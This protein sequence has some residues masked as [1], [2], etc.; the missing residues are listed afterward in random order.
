MVERSKSKASQQAPV[1]YVGSQG[2]P[3]EKRVVLIVPTH[4]L[5]RVD[6]V[7]LSQ[8]SYLDTLQPSIN[9]SPCYS[10]AIGKC[11]I[12]HYFLGCIHTEVRDFLEIDCS[13]KIEGLTLWWKLEQ[14]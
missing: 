2:T 7:P 10:W 6:I 13:S 12:S 8:I 5:A 9:R 4:C 1:T 3:S 14:C 11:C